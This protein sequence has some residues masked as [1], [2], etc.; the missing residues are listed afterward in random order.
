MQFSC[1]NHRLRP[2]PSEK[3]SILT[4]PNLFEELQA[5]FL[6]ME[7]KMTLGK[8]SNRLTFCVNLGRE[9]RACVKEW[10]KKRS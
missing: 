7:V 8:P 4:N 9:G 2:T 1:R 6:A 5:T 3:L 10:F